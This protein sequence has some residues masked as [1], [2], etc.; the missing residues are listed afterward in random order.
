MNNSISTTSAAWP[1]NWPANSF[2]GGPTALLILAALGA[3]VVG[4]VIGV[5][6]FLGA[7]RPRTMGAQFVVSAIWVQLLVEGA[8]VI[9]ILA[10]L[11]AVSKRS[12]R[13]LGFYM[14]RPWQLG[15]ALIGAIAMVIV[16]EGGASIIQTLTHTKHEQSVVELFKQVVGQPRVMWFFAV[17]AIVLAPFMEEVIFRIFIFNVGLRWGGFWLGAIISGLCFGAAHTDLF[18]LV[19][20][21][22]GGIILCA[23]YY[24]T[25]NA[26]C[27]MVTHGLFNAVTV[28]ALMFA[29]QLA[30]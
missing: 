24:R 16:V 26:F 5:L 13:E 12:L 20:L 2:R 1:T 19:P 14:P 15:I 23:V 30:Q 4:G 11:P 29:P 10:G 21:A 27:S 22:L 9:V 17:F 28:F 8:A 18:V 25:G 3:A 6:F 7:H